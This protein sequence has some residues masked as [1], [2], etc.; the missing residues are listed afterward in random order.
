MSISAPGTVS[1]ADIAA[2]LSDSA[3]IAAL[4]PQGR[5]EAAARPA[6][7]LVPILLRPAP[8]VLLTLRA[9]NLSAHAGQVSFPGGRIEPGETPEDAA[10]R[11]AEEEV[12]LDRSGA[13]VIGR[14][15]EHLTGTGYRIT[16]IVALLPPPGALRPDPSEVAEAFEYALAHLLAPGLPEQREGLWRGRPGVSWVWPHERHM[17]WGATAAILRNLALL[18]R[19]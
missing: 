15:P 7:V 3:R 13:R 18:L 16:P 6:A 11:E 4:P 12:G 2:R 9:P 19:D 8:T 10:L 5:E 17:I 1:A 14:L